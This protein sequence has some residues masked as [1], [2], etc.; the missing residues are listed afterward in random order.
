M[1][2]DENLSW[3]GGRI[4]LPVTELDTSVFN[5]EGAIIMGLDIGGL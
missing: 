2:T 1:P 3:L 5:E 4:E